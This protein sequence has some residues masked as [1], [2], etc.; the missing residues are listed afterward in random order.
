MKVT[1]ISTSDLGGAASAC[2]RLHKA[3]LKKGVESRVLVLDKYKPEQENV[4]SFFNDERKVK[5]AFNFFLRHISPTLDQR[6]LKGK[7]STYEIFSFPETVLKVH[8]HDIV[9][10][11]EIVHLHFISEFVDYPSFFKNTKKNF[12]WTLHDM[13]PFTGG[14]HYAAECRKFQKQCTDCPQLKGTKNTDR[15]LSIQKLKI[16]TMKD[17]K[18]QVVVSPSEWLKNESQSSRVFED[19]IHYKIPHGIDTKEFKPHNKKFARDVFNLGHKEKLLLF[20]ADDFKR[21]NKGFDVLLNALKQIKQDF[22]LITVGGLGNRKINAD[23]KHTHLGYIEDKTFLSVAYSAADITVVPSIYEAFSL[24]TLESLA[25]GT[26][27]VAFDNTGPS[28]IIKHLETGYLAGIGHIDELAEGI[29]H[30]LF[31]DKNLENYSKQARED[32]LKRFDINK[33][34]DQ[35][36]EVY[37]SLNMK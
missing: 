27:T 18:N 21:H 19:K 7:I 30:I 12:V 28:E 33:T 17:I 11:A 36:I 10:D 8:K 23:I 16:K 6:K 31:D 35:Y 32:V 9:R 24:T 29:S 15:S 37:T 34:A 1:H 13:N 26:P 2:L 4:F 22:R 25:S 14:C 3:L 20:I 5:K